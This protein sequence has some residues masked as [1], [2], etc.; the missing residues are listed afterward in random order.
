MYADVNAI[1]SRLITLKTLFPTADVGALVAKAPK[2][3][4]LKDEATLRED[5]AKARRTLYR[6]C[7]VF[8][9]NVP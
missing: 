6:H 1:T 9:S 4:L 3:L 8:V 2:M 7:F 5:A